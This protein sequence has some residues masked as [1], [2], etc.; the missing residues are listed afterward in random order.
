MGSPSADKF[1]TCVL[2]RSENDAIVR[3]GALIL[4][5]LVVPVMAVLLTLDALWIFNT[6]FA[7]PTEVIELPNFILDHMDDFVGAHMMEYTI[8]T[9]ILFFL[10]KAFYDHCKRD[11]M[12]M[13]A[14]IGY[15]EENG[16]DASKLKSIKGEM[17]IGR[18]DRIYKVYGVW[19]VV[20]G[21][22]CVFQALFISMRDLE[23]H[24][25]VAIINGLIFVMIAQLSYTT[26]FLIYFI[27]IYD[28]VQVRFTEEYQSLMSDLLP[29]LGVMVDN[30]KEIKMA[31]YMV[32]TILT[33]GLLSL[34]S[35]FWAVHTLNIHIK[36]QWD[37]E[38]KLMR[39]IAKREKAIRVEVVEDTDD[40]L[41][42]L[43]RRMMRS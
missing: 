6:Y 22:C 20:V 40:S 21:L 3:V 39:I 17:K 36:N 10:M 14:L 15:A 19:F 7:D 33:L 12:W 29:D 31:P 25:A 9:F 42:G 24:T 23:P 11:H 43:A 16:R 2:K 8:G 1:L 27:N 13:D 34:F 35:M 41:K 26:G 18:A 4:I 37:Y 30:I 5:M 38:E 28:E 32:I